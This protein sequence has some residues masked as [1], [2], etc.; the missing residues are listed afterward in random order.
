M[1]KSPGIPYS[2]NRTTSP[3][4]ASTSSSSNHQSIGSTSSTSSIAK[5]SGFSSPSSNME[6]GVSVSALKD[7]ITKLAD[8]ADVK[9][10]DLPPPVKRDLSDVRK[11]LSL[12]SDND[13]YESIVEHIK[14]VF[15]DHIPYPNTVASSLVGCM[16]D[17]IRYSSNRG[18]DAACAGSVG[19]EGVQCDKHVF[20]RDSQGITMKTSLS[21]DK[22][23]DAVIHCQKNY[24]QIT[25]REI[26]YLQAL[27]IKHVTI[28]N[29]KEDGTYDVIVQRTPITSLLNYASSQKSTKK[30]SSLSE[31]STSSSGTT[32]ST[33]PTQSGSKSASTHGTY[34][35]ESESESERSRSHSSDRKKHK[36]PDQGSW[37]YIIIIAILLI[38]IVFCIALYFVVTS[39]WWKGQKSDT[40][41]GGNTSIPQNGVEGCSNSGGVLSVTEGKH[42]GPGIVS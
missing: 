5:S 28:T 19:S 18:C 20:F 8:Y 2:L 38:I 40:P 29:Y 21:P 6:R 31:S 4:I 25:E 27:G 22:S 24:D 30:T 34:E 15:K 26:R 41:C 3:S 33:C 14:T 16:S 32:Q 13:R 12:L 10:D 7:H 36:K 23:E 42:Y 9:I 39:G 37:G 35:S 11:L 1:R 17:N